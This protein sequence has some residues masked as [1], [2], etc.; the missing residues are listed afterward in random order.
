MSKLIDF[1]AEFSHLTSI[2]LKDYSK[3]FNLTVDEKEST[4]QIIFLPEHL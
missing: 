4:G 3:G 1:I 2:N